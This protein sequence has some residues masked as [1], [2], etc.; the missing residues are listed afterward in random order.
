MLVANARMYTVDRATDAAWR[1]WMRWIARAADVP[2]RYEPHPPP[3]SLHTLW[4]RDDLGCALMCGYPLATW[5]DAATRPCVLAAMA[6][7]SGQQ[8]PV[9]ALYRTAIV[10]RAD[11]EVRAVEDLRGRRFAFTT[12]GSQSGYQA[13]REWIA[14]RALETG[15]RLF[16]TTVGPLVTPRAIVD[17]VLGGEAD[18]GPLDGHWLEL[19]QLHDPDTAARLRIVEFTPWSPMPPFVCS[20]ALSLDLRTRLRDALLA[21]GRADALHAPRATLRIHGV[22]PAHASDYE[23]LAQRARATDALGYPSLQ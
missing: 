2:L 1:E 14:S 21:A 16:A 4:G 23:V 10:S 6:G 9:R 5:D 13:V 18:A 19:L 12:P 17:A 22:L 20:A 3:L 11:G 15:G 7:A 8:Q